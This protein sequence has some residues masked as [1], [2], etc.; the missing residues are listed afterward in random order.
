MGSLM[1]RGSFLELERLLFE[2][3]HAYGKSMKDI[4]FVFTFLPFFFFCNRGLAHSSSVNPNENRE[5]AKKKGEIAKKGNKSKSSK[6]QTPQPSVLVQRAF[7]I[8]VLFLLLCVLPRV[9][10]IFLGG[11]VVYISSRAFP[12]T[13]TALPTTR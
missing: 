6:V 4:P 5:R 8:S 9:T 2:S 7:V 13:S 11:Q 3:T 12:L 10:P 1:R